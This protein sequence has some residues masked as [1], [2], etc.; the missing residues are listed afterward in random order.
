MKEEQNLTLENLLGISPI[1]NLSFFLH[2]YIVFT[3]HYSRIRKILVN[4]NWTPS[5]GQY[6][7]EIKEN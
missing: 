5:R 7:M 3:S 2:I 1:S 6:V 4:F